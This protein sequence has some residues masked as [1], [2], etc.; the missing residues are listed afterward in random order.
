MKVGIIEYGGDF[1]D[2]FIDATKYKVQDIYFEKKRVIDIFD[3]LAYLKKWQDFDQLV[4]VVDTY[5]KNHESL[6]GFYNALANFEAQTGKIVFKCLYDSQK[7]SAVEAVAETAEKFMNFLFRPEEAFKPSEK[8]PEPPG[9]EEEPIVD[10]EKEL[11][12]DFPEEE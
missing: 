8:P 7:Q 10:L 9:Y 4:I 3:V 12:E 2:I 5:E 11:E 1:S 6:D